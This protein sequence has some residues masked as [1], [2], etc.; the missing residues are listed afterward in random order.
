MCKDTC[1]YEIAVIKQEGIKKI[2]FRKKVEDISAEVYEDIV[3]RSDYS[4][5][6]GCPMN[7]VRSPV[8]M[9]ISKRLAQATK[10]LSGELAEYGQETILGCAT[11]NE[12]RACTR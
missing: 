3:A 5:N 4:E 8:M 1:H 9:G 11:G 2:V 10:L 6:R 12:G 7:I